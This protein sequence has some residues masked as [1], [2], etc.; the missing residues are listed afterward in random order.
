[1]NVS[2]LPSV[3]GGRRWCV[4]SVPENKLTPLKVALAVL[5][6]YPAKA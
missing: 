4:P 3:V 1:V 6:M 5:V 2:P